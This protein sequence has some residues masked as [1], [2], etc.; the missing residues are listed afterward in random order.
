MRFTDEQILAAIPEA[1][2]QSY[3]HTGGGVTAD[4]LAHV[5]AAGTDPY[6]SEIYRPIIARK[7][8]AMARRGLLSHCTY[9]GWRWF[10]AARVEAS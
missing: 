8:A 2:R 3:G 4:H 9:A 6:Q 10:R 7:C 5:L 1:S